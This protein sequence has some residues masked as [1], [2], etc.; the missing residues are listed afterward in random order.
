MEISTVSKISEKHLIDIDIAKI[1]GLAKG[2]I[3]QYKIAALI[4][5]S[6][7]VVQQTLIIY[8]FKTF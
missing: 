3:S 4:K 6:K 8:V 5:Y 1:L 7:I 2:L